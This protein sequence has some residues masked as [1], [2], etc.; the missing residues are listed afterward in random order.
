LKTGPKSSAE[1]A[2]PYI[3]PSPAPPP[4]D[5][6][7]REQDIWREIAARQRAGF[8]DAPNLIMLKAL[9]RHI[10]NSDF[11]AGEIAQ[12]RSDGDRNSG[13]ELG[14]LLRAHSRES[15]RVGRLSAQLRLTPG[16]R[17]SGTKAAQMARKGASGPKPWTDWGGGRQ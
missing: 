2:A 14:A 10:N 15:E 11:L 16:I 13:K 3:A 17:W 8:F 1:R 4:A 12:A 7:E 6:D 5:L 9:V